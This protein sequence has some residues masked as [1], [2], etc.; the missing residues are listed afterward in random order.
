MRDQAEKLLNEG[1]G[2]AKPAH[3]KPAS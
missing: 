3:K 2:G 1:A